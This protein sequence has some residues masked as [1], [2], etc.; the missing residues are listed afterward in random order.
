MRGHAFAN[1]EPHAR[2]ERNRRDYIKLK[3]QNDIVLLRLEKGD[4]AKLDA[5]SKAAGLSRAAFARAYLMPMVEALGCRMDAVA[6]ARS[7]RGQ[8]L[9][10]FITEAL[11]GAIAR[12]ALSN[13]TPSAKVAA[14][15]DALFGPD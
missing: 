5:A 12:A 3:A 6:M 8:N 11:D 10:T 15:F 13:D 2:V 4:A 9:A 14:E 7:T 1:T